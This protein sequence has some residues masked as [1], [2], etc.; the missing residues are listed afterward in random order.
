MGKLNISDVYA[1][2]H[3]T[4]REDPVLQDLMGFTPSTT[5]EEMA[6]RIQKRRKPQ[7]LVEENLPL[8]S[9]YKNPGMRGGDNYLEYRTHFDFDIYTQDDVELAIQIADRISELFDDEYVGL[10]KGSYFKGE[11][12]T[13][14]EDNTDLENI[15][16]YFTQIRYTLVIE[17]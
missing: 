7:N 14:A 4:L 11:Y 5:L 3:K 12:L 1:F 6:M 8:I 10:K 2:I 15:Y 9:F 17:E 16:K 13:S